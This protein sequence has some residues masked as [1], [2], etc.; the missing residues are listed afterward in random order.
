[1]MTTATP[2]I[3]SMKPSSVPI[4]HA[5]PSSSLKEKIC[6]TTIKIPIPLRKP[7]MTDSGMILVKR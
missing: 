7:I 3:S 2:A 1:M 6:E 4:R 5:C